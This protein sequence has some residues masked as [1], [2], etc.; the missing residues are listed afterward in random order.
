MKV[1]RP[2]HI[3]A[4][5]WDAVTMQYDRLDRAFTARDF[6]QAIGTAKELCETV[7]KIVLQHA[8]AA[9][10]GSNADF[11]EVINTAHSAAGR[12][13]AAGMADDELRNMAM[14]AKKLV[15]AVGSL[16]N[17]VGSG[18]G[19]A[20]T[21]DVVEEQATVAV[22]AAELWCGWMLRRLDHVARGRSDTLVDELRQGATFH[23]GVLAQR[24]QDVGLASLEDDEAFRLGV[25]VGQRASS[26]TFVV[27][28]D[29]VSAVLADPNSWPAPYI[30]GVVTGAFLDANGYLNVAPALVREVVQL[31]RHVADPEATAIA[32]VTQ[33]A[34]A[35]SAYSFHSPSDRP[36]SAVAAMKE[37][38]GLVPPA[39]RSAWADLTALVSREAALDD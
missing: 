30:E 39:A 33:V 8:G 10:L 34:Q 29:G 21:P 2:Q 27:H 15:L 25:A 18:H 5:E 14:S 4:E 36:A 1:A 22:Q 16:R 38:A 7:A 32:L 19:R 13:P 23:A 37:A 35:E 17:R 24:L 12:Q 6:S 26:N 28:A 3:R 31:L 20:T 11:P 9:P